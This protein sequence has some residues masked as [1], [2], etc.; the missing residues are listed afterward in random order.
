M[1]RRN[2]RRKTVSRFP[3]IALQRQSH[4]HQ[5]NTA[6]DQNRCRQGFSMTFE[7][8]RSPLPIVT[9][10]LPPQDP[11]QVLPYLREEKQRRPPAGALLVT[12][13]RGLF[14]GRFLP[15][16]AVGRDFRDRAGTC[17]NRKAA[18]AGTSAFPGRPIDSI[19]APRYLVTWVLGWLGG[20]RDANCLWNGSATG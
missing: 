1:I 4:K 10:T 17:R 19:P 18:A 15:G 20:V 8:R 7:A 12:S 14:L 11:G 5:A 9:H 3:G 16:I 6:G 13:H 2:S